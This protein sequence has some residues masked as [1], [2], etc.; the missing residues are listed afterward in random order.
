MVHAFLYAH[1]MF[2]AIQDL[3]KEGAVVGS[4]Y[5][6]WLLPRGLSDCFGLLAPWSV[7][8]KI[9]PGQGKVSSSFSRDM[10]GVWLLLHAHIPA[11]PY[12]PWYHGIL[13][14]YRIRYDENATLG[15]WGGK[16]VLMHV[17]SLAGCRWFSKA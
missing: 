4:G 10:E 13:Y 9:K 8:G 15:D 1:Y 6:Q 3:A 7:E 11:I 5:A 2:Q 12:I 16:R 14:I 17:L